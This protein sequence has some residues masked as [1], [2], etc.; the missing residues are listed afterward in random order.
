MINFSSATPKGA[1]REQLHKKN[2]EQEG[3][4]STQTLVAVIHS[5]DDL[6]ESFKRKLR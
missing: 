5:D 2:R 3:Y 1:Q 6:V 4:V